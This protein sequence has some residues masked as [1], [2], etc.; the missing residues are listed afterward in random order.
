MLEKELVVLPAT[1]T[2][3]FINCSLNLYNFSVKNKIK[4]SIKNIK[5][6]PSQWDTLIKIYRKHLTEH[7]DR[8]RLEGDPL[9]LATN[10]KSCF[11]LFNI[12][13]SNVQRST[14]SPENLLLLWFAVLPLYHSQTTSAA[15]IV[16]FIV[17]NTQFKSHLTITKQ[18]IHSY[19]H[20]P[21]IELM[22]VDSTSSLQLSKVD[23][24]SSC[25]PLKQ[26]AY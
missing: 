4:D 10:D 16:S 18:N 13:C 24:Y 20:F 15:G 23:R 12:L 14:H 25:L 11:W 26:M 7:G 9:P 1:N 19:L 21:C 22:S 8:G 6:S 2:L 5:S 17:M 3:L